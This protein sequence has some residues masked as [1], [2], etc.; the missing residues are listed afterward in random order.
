MPDR[1]HQKRVRLTARDMTILEELLHLR[2]DTLGALHHRHWRAGS[3]RDSARH[4]LSRL[5]AWGY[6]DKHP[7]QQPPG[8]LVHPGDTSSGWVTVYTLTPRGVAALRRRSFAGS[9]LRARSIKGDI[10]EA[11]IPH[12][13]AVNRIG[14]LLATTLTLDHLLDLSG[15]RRHRPDAT[16][17]SSPD[18]SGRCS[19]ML[20]VDLGHYSRQRILGKLRTFLADPDAKGVLFACPTES[21]AAWIAETLRDAH[22]E[23]IMDR[24]QVLTFDEIKQGRLLRDALRPT[25]E[26]HLDIADACDLLPDA[27]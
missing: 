23:R 27:A 1:P 15:D 26:H 11:A 2:A 18:A 10:D 13:L 5:A 20:E 8:A 12:Q 21:R 4:R 19:V 22:G 24:V 14:E 17:R 3:D 9:L 25:N 6:I 16:Y 7:I